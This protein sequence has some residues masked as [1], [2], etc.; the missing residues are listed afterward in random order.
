MLETESLIGSVKSELFEQLLNSIDQN[1]GTG[2]AG[3]SEYQANP[4]KFGEKVLGEGM[5]RRKPAPAVRRAVA[6]ENREPRR[7]T[8]R[9]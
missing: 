1:F 6:A 5:V 2:E 9:A 7:G 3:F 8:S 4:I